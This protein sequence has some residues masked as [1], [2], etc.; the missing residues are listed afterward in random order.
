LGLPVFVLLPVPVLVAVEVALVGLIFA[1]SR[2]A[3]VGNAALGSTGQK[4]PVD[5]GQ[6]GVGSVD[7]ALSAAVME[8]R[9]LLKAL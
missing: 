8:A 4:G 1:K 7:D 5:A 2:P 3:I 6:D 9:W